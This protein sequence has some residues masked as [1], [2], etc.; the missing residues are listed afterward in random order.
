MSIEEDL[1]EDILLLMRDIL[2]S[3]NLIIE[4]TI[5]ISDY[6]MDSLDYIN[7]ITKIEDCYCIELPDEILI[8]IYK[9]TIDDISKKVLECINN[10][11]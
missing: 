4:S 10:K 7:L 1:H 2:N 8:D 3:H 5:K 11:L 6:G 9:I